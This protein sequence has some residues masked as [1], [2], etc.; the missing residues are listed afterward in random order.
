MRVLVTGGSGFIGTHL[1]NYLEAAGHEVSNYDLKE[2]DDIIEDKKLLE[3][4]KGMDTVY[5]LAA[6][7]NPAADVGDLYQ[8]NASS[9]FLA[10]KHANRRNVDKF[11]FTSSAAVYG[12]SGTS[13]VPIKKLD[14]LSD[15]GWS[16]REAERGL[17]LFRPDL[18]K[19]VIVRPFNVYGPGQMPDSPYS[20]VISKFINNALADEPLEIYGTGVQTRDFIFVEDLVRIL[21]S[22]TEQSDETVGPINLGTGTPTSISELAE[23]IVEL[24]NSKSQIHNTDVRLGD[25]LHS[26]AD[27]SATL[28]L[29][30]KYEIEPPNTS[31]EQGLE[32]TIEWFKSRQN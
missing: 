14:P 16:K 6:I 12:N 2:G 8:V 5:H 21:V 20:G 19:S 25:I 17:N 27:M 31:L 24:T 4:L 15:Y 13:L 29:L 18:I 26:K 30:Q 10:M 9:T 23:K 32:R 22:L 28:D 3:K 1:R 7:I 11:A